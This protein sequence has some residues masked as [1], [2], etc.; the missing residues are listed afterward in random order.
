MAVF[1]WFFFLTLI[2]TVAFGQ[3]GGPTEK[4]PHRPPCTNAEC[5]KI[6]SFLKAHYCGASPFA[7]GP[8][9]GCDTR[10]PK[11]LSAGI[12][13][14]ADFACHWDEKIGEAKC[15]QRGEPTPE[16]KSILLREMRRLGL[17]QQAVPELY[18]VVWQPNSEGWTLAGAYYGHVSGTE[19][20]LCQLIAVID[21]N[22]TVHPLHEVRLQK[23][24]ADVPEV[25]GW[26]AVDIADVNGDGHM[27]I[28]LEGDA[29]ENH[30][31][32]VYGNQRGTFKM[33]FSGLGYY[34]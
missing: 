17:P 9:D 10:V 20:K 14:T 4:D 31:Y 3:E 12:K 34:L 26:S 2:L 8:D 18:F 27:E 33:I 23:T 1:R 15:Q 11:K 7:N 32:E 30:W 28:I 6:T 16:L 24:D 21:Q 19:L 22:G 5:R 25:T 29:Y 13:S